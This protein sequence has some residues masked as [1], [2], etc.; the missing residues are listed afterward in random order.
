MLAADGG[1]RRVLRPPR[2]RQPRLPLP[3]ARP[4]APRRRSSAAA[5][6]G[7]RIRLD[8]DGAARLRR[9]PARGARL[10]RLHAHRRLPPRFD[11][12]V[13]RAGWERARRRARV[14]DR[15]RR[16]HAPDEPRAGRHDARGRQRP[17]RASSEFARCSRGARA[18]RPAAP[19]RRT[20][21]T[22][23]PSR[24]WPIS[25]KAMLQSPP[26]QRRRHRRHRAADAAPRAAGA[27]GRR[28]G[29]RSR[30]T[31]T[32]RPPRARSRSAGRC[33]SPRS[34]FEDGTLGY[35]CDGTPVDCVRLASLGLIEG[36]EP[37]LIVS[38]INHGSNLGD[39]I[40]Y[41][42]TVAAAL[43][44]VVLGDPGHRRLPAVAGRARWTSGSASGST[45]TA[46]AAFAARIVDRL[47]DV[48]LPE[49][50][51]LNINVPAGHARRRRGRAAGQAHLPG[52]A[53]GR[54]GGGRPPA[55]PHLRRLA[56]ARRR[57][58]APTWPRCRRAA[59]RSRR[60]T[61]T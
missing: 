47:D 57:G 36:F 18:P 45:S 9:R 12:E 25:S 13:L 26:H 51:L 6:S 53:G 20:G 21:S 19:R 10:H 15:G 7:T 37:D 27:R 30:R 32:A 1:A 52:R 29:G 59:C 43:E 56:R 40:T 5:R 28:A 34:T 8:E 31:P 55:L 33:G 4:R 38:G 46:A 61:S 58:R 60:C 54:R 41:S 16:L 3:R 44:G 22:S 23:S 42:G 24:Y 2:R 39:D 49:G 48:P 35:A 14:L 50:T 17:A 11:R